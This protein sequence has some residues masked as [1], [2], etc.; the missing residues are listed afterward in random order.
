M[1]RDGAGT[2]NRTTGTYTGSTSWQQ[3][4]DALR[5]IRADDHDTHDQDIANALTQSLSKDGQTTP[6]ANL[7]MGGFAHTNVA[8]ATARTQYGKV[9]Q[10]QDT[11]YVWGGT[12]G[13]T[14]SAYT[15]SLTPAITAY[16]T[17]MT[18]RVKFNA[19]CA[20]TPTI[21]LNGVS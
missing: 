7:P 5:K 21:N 14:S 8:D 10:I 3:T 2:Y 13:G 9:S 20:A 18:I 17:G 12:T 6:T 11:G 1:A 4:R 19:A 15:A 16:A